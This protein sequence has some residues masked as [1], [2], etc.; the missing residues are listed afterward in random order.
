MNARRCV[1][2][3][4]QQCKGNASAR[5]VLSYATS[6]WRIKNAQECFLTVHF[7]PNFFH[8][9]AVYLSI[10]GT[11]LSGCSKVFCYQIRSCVTTYRRS[12]I[13]T[14]DRVNLY[15]CHIC[16]ELTLTIALTVTRQV[17]LGDVVH[18]WVSIQYAN[19]DTV[20]RQHGHTVDICRLEAE[21]LNEHWERRSFAIISWSRCPS[22]PLDIGHGW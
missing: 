3:Q 15:T 9:A 12:Q 4:F 8:S 18:L 20:I 22:N 2:P 21:L 13:I 10:V 19:S 11:T 1:Y 6:P 7:L 5:S 16:C 14:V 17:K